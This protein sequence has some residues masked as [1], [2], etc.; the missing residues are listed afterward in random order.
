MSR[1]GNESWPTGILSDTNPEAGCPEHGSG[2]SVVRRPF[3]V[4]TVCFIHSV[5]V[6]VSPFTLLLSVYSSHAFVL[7]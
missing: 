6:P 1:S 5:G 4:L 3:S 2:G 7:C